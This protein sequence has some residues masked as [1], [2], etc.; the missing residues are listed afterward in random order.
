MGYY[1]PTPIQERAIPA[2]LDGHDIIGSAQTG[3]GKT[4]AFI[5]PL[6][7][8]IITSQ[9]RQNVKALVIVPTRE[10]AVQ[11]TQQ[12]DGMGYFTPVRGMAVYGG[13]DGI[14]FAREK[15]AM[16]N[17]VEIIIGTPGRLLS[18][19]N[20]RY[21]DLSEL[22]Y[23]VLDEAD[24]MLDMGFYE[25]IMRL[26]DFL[27][28]KRQNLMFSATMPSKI[29]TLALQILDNPVEISIG[30][31]KPAEN[32]TQRAFMVNENQKIPIITELI[33]REKQQSTIIFCST[34]VSVKELARELRRAKFAVDEIHSDL[35]QKKREEVMQQF[36]AR[37]LNILVA[38]DILARGI[39]IEDIDL[40]INFNV[41]SD[42]ES[43]IH[44]IGRTARA[45]SNGS[46]YTFITS[47]D[48]HYF[49]DIETLLGYSVEQM[50]IDESFGETP[51][52]K[53]RSQNE[54]RSGRGNSRGKQVHGRNSNARNSN[55]SRGGASNRTRQKRTPESRTGEQKLDSK[56]T[57]NAANRGEENAPQ[58][59]PQRNFN[60]NKGRRR[61]NSPQKPKEDGA[62]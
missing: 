21:I 5:L 46:A 31:S 54:R 41:P 4:A 39:D 14:A 49:R 11:I 61:G 50:Q 56:P 10:L 17:G 44:R 40:V 51:D 57:Q 59:S 35:E 28:E 7:N 16:E 36:K 38:T 25:D 43:Y 12:V 6:I 15:S 23:L 27:P 24:R 34:K 58:K 60:K 20:M 47:K 48:Q 18:H 42:G 22:E 55:K 37:E 9:K 19:F 62:S 8:Q 53:P 2:I 1:T 26:I 13:S 29:R 52:Y 33:R 45:A 32:V 3:T 30:I